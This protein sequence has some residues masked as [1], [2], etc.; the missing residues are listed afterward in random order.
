MLQTSI[1]NKVNSNSSLQSHVFNDVNDLFL[2]K[3]AV[4]LL[5]QIEKSALSTQL[6]NDKQ[7]KVIVFFGVSCVHKLHY[8]LMF[9]Q[10]FLYNAD[11]QSIDIPIS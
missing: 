8:V 7:V 6:A 4:I 5:E 9:A 3:F 11:Y 1:L 2:G 10:K